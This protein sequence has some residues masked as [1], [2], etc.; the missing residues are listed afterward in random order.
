MYNPIYLH[1][2]I[3]ANNKK[4][5]KIKKNKKKKK[6]KKQLKKKVTKANGGITKK[7]YRK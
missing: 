3:K 6:K 1:R 5:K 2:K 4:K 7:N